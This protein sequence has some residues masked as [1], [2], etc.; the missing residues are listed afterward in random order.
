MPERHRRQGSWTPERLVQWA[1]R[2]GPDTRLW[3]DSRLVEKAHPE[4]AYRVCLGLLNLSRNYPPERLNASCRIAN[5]EG[6]GRLKQ[7]RAILSGNRDQLQEQLP[8]STAELPQDHA[9]IRG[10]SNFQ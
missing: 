7:I 3:V 1:Q 6:L 9:N 5:R 2:I 8:L 10:P 4:Q